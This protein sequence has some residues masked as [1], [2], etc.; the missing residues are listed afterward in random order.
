MAT[1]GHILICSTDAPDTDCHSLDTEIERISDPAP[2]AVIH[3]WTHTS[4]EVLQHPV[5]SSKCS[6]TDVAGQGS[7]EI[8]KPLATG[9]P[10]NKLPFKYVC[11][12][13]H[14]L[15]VLEKLIAY[16]E[17]DKGLW[18]EMRKHVETLPDHGV[19]SVELSQGVPGAA[20]TPPMALECTGMK[21]DMYMN[22]T[23]LTIVHAMK[24]RVGF[25]PFAGL[26]DDPI[27]DFDNYR[28]GVCVW[29][30]PSSHFDITVDSATMFI[31]RWQ[32]VAN[33]HGT[34]VKYTAKQFHAHGNS[35]Q[36]AMVLA[37]ALHLGET[38]VW[39]DCFHQLAFDCS[40]Y[41]ANVR[42][43]EGYVWRD[44][45]PG[46]LYW[47]TQD[48]LQDGSVIE[49][50]Y[51]LGA[52]TGLDFVEDTLNAFTH[53]VCVETGHKEIMIDFQGETFPALNVMHADMDHCPQAS[54][55]TKCVRGWNLPRCV[56]TVNGS[57]MGGGSG[58]ELHD[59][60]HS[61][62][63]Y[64]LGTHLC[65]SFCELLHLHELQQHRE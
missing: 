7:S 12:H 60:G 55:H 41:L 1:S 56:L 64:Y 51:L 8:T 17:T 61:A 35:K 59:G 65:G 48:E 6:S 30:D 13:A 10:V 23:E 9:A 52:T 2:M 53:F 19:D 63:E 25:H 62:L 15:G 4:S 22:V 26:D 16:G 18:L 39:W 31:G 43:V 37:E 29:L 28:P 45:E 5:K 50:T 21:D 36:D 47:Y 44:T 11:T 33:E 38:A 54:T 57:S 32:L 24:E 46:R 14:D 42:F 3:K 34:L 20:S 40:Q 27:E 58:S 49:I